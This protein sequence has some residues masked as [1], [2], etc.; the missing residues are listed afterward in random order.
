MQSQVKFNR[1]SRRSQRKFWELWCSAR[2]GSTGF[3][4]RFR[5]RSGRLRCSRSGSTGFRRRFRRRSRDKVLEKVPGGFG[6]APGQ[7][8][9][10]SGQGSGEGL[11][12][13]GAE[14]GEVQQG[15]RKPY[16][17]AES[18]S[19]GSGEGCRAGPAMV[20][21]IFDLWCRA[22]SGQGFQRLASQHASERFLKIK[23]CGCW[24]YH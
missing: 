3:R 15:F 13:F 14:A 16:C 10:G 5:R 7:V 18:G 8:Q 24:G 4:R 17:K 6:A 23:R 21:G 1:V 19:T 2:S 9:Q 12:G 11:G 22:R 20:L